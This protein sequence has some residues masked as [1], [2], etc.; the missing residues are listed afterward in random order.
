MVIVVKKKGH[1]EK[2][3]DGKVFKSIYSATLNC[4]LPEE[5]AERIAEK[6]TFTI[7]AW[8]NGK[9]SITADQIEMEILKYL[10]LENSEIVLMY[11]HHKNIC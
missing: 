9:K 8:V 11:Q 4:H 1:A 6:L 5:E 2:Y 3:D 10:E 7:D